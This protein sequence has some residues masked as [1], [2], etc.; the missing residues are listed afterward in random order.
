MKTAQNTISL[1]LAGI[2]LLQ[3]YATLAFDDRPASWFQ[4]KVL[5]RRPKPP[6]TSVQKLARCMDRLEEELLEDGSVVA[7]A[8]DVWGEARLTAHRAEFE[9][10]LATRVGEFEVRMN[11]SMSRSD[12]AFLAGALALSNTAAAG[13]GGSAGQTP[14]PNFTQ[15][16]QML[17]GLAPGNTAAQGS[18]QSSPSSMTVFNS[19]PGQLFSGQ[20]PFATGYDKVELEQTIEL[21]QLSR[22]LNHLHELRRMNEGDDTADAPGYSLNLVRIPVSI[23][24]GSKT[25]RGHSAEITITAEP[26]VTE[27]LLPATF[28][29]L[30]INDL[31]DQLTVPVV[32]DLERVRK[33]QEALRTAHQNIRDLV[34]ELCSAARYESIDLTWFTLEG[35]ARIV[36]GLERRYSDVQI[37]A[38]ITKVCDTIDQLAAATDA[39]QTLPL[40]Q[41]L[42][43]LLLPV[44]EEFQKEYPDKV[45]ELAGL[46]PEA[47]SVSRM[48]ASPKNPAALETFQIDTMQLVNSVSTRESATQTP[49]DQSPKAAVFTGTFLLRNLDTLTTWLSADLARSPLLNNIISSARNLNT[50]GAATPSSGH[51]RARSPLAGE[52]LRTILGNDLQQLLLQISKHVS[53]SSSSRASTVRNLLRDELENAYETVF[54]QTAFAAITQ[55]DL[56][57]LERCLATGSDTDHQ[58]QRFANVRNSWNVHGELRRL[59]CWPILVESLLLNR[60][61]NADIRHVSQDPDCACITTDYDL[62]FYGMN[63]DPTARMAFVQY[64]K[65]RW[66]IHVFALDPVVQEQNITDQYSMRRELQLAMALALSSGRIS[67]QTATRFARRLEMDME[68]VALNRTVV[69][70]GHGRDTFGW[71][72][73]PRAQTPEFESNGKVVFRELLLGG[74]DRDDLKKQWQLEPGMR[75]C[76]AVVLMPS[77]ITHVRFDSRGHFSPLVCSHLGASTPA[78]TR[79]SI[80]DTVEMSRM[81]KELQDYAICAQNESNLYR[82]GEV[83]RLMR[84][85]EQLSDRLPL[86]T[87]Y[88][89]VPNENTLGG[90]EMFSSGVT[91]LAPELYD[92]FGE[93]GAQAGEVTRVFLIGSNFSVTGTRVIAGNTTV[94]HTLLSREVMEVVIPADA[95]ADAQGNIDIHVATPY[96]V[97]QHLQIQPSPPPAALPRLSWG[98]PVQKIIHRW[99]QGDA[100]NAAS[101][102]V[103]GDP[104]LPEGPWEIAV[105]LPPET[106]SNAPVPAEVTL[107]L[108]ISHNTGNGQTVLSAAPF[109]GLKYSPD[110]H[111]YIL[112]GAAFLGLHSDLRTK[113]V[114][115][116][117]SLSRKPQPPGT[118]NLQLT[119]FITPKEGANPRV[120]VAGSMKLQVEFVPV[121]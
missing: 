63:P 34:N 105:C 39:K 61:L 106:R 104:M 93:P 121:E 98:A 51:R 16:N 15:I 37:R 67:A 77:F 94:E 103:E 28:R 66:P 52:N 64:V 29:A 44:M 62:T 43:Q 8:P 35:F 11:A 27:E 97:S 7:K 40:V 53:S 87:T 80:S 89:R 85:V 120:E 57:E 50:L 9:K 86:Q 14:N 54:E 31:V 100:G 79:S 12:Q 42:V 30:V 74:P 23:L 70:F 33:R 69:A 91:D 112:E 58:R 118:L 83:D 95:L 47:I 114:S 6:E 90:F 78:D 59:L 49:A 10:Q 71:R 55:L 36:E 5:G 38:Q 13:T 99:K 81:V 107:N 24:P 45:L 68:T 116:L 88:S 96:G 3:P 117:K 25:R 20:S 18:S 4:S 21:D 17:P 75:E 32:A 109:S 2:L 108:T 101:W 22:Y 115:R 72:F 102:T 19:P 84:R 113:L 111:A 48:Q 41:L 26:V 73:S 110:R 60:Q 76:L 82:D 56:I 119:G 1:L 65:C 92:W 46:L